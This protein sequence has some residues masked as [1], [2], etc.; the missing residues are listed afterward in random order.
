[1]TSGLWQRSAGSEACTGKRPGIDAGIAHE[2]VSMDTAIPSQQ[3]RTPHVHTRVHTQAPS[4]H[5]LLSLHKLLTAP[6]QQVLGFN[7]SLL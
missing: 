3:C 5:W 1:M 4:T 6:F 7:Q 2:T